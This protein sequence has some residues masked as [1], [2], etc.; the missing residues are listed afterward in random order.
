M[1]RHAHARRRRHRRQHRRLYVGGGAVALVLAGI[2]LSGGLPFRSGSRADGSPGPAA[3]C[4]LPAIELRVI[5]S[6]EKVA[7][8]GAI[9]EAY[10][11]TEPAVDGRCLKIHIGHASSA[12]ATGLSGVATGVPG[13]PD[14]WTPESTLWVKALAT[15]S[16]PMQVVAALDHPSIAMSPTVL[17]MPRPM[18]EALGWP[19]QTL[20][21]AKLRELAAA[22]N[23]WASLGHPEWGAFRLDHIDPRLSTAKAQTTLALAYNVTGTV[24][25]LAADIA[26]EKVVRAL[27]KLDRA[28]GPSH[29]DT[30]VFLA[31]LRDADDAG[32][33]LRHISVAALDEMSVLAYN[34]GNSLG[35]PM[36]EDRSDW[37]KIPLAAFYP[38]EGTFVSDHPYV[39]LT[40]AP[41]RRRAA[42]TFLEHLRTPAAQAT[43][44]RYGFRDRRGVSAAEVTADQGVLARQPVKILPQPDPDVASALLQDVGKLRTRSNVLTVLDVSGSMA[45]RVSGQLTR[46]DLAKQAAI[47]SLALYDAHDDGGLWSFTTRHRQLVSLGPLNDEVDGGATRRDLIRAQIAKL[48]PGNDTALYNTAWAAHQRVVANYQRDTRNSVILLTDGRNDI[49]GGLNLNALLARLSKSDRFRPVRI[50]LIAYGDNVDLPALRKIAAAT[51][52]QVFEA[53]NPA[54]IDRVF[55]LAIASS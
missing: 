6:A 5:S 25:P 34:H 21:L 12:L 50:N 53:P 42:T 3:R 43:L 54:N 39:I 16:T 24:R 9:A 2:V 35:V 8:L 14:V 17:A 1:A 47:N 51:G 11:K 10:Q 40:D 30:T 28:P 41:D 46:M 38:P 19:D 22:K 18:A 23:G 45:V 36:N 15:S 20:G 4:A 32:K 31:G 29:A 55:A 49:V 27:L 26:S 33:A 48:T 7:A 13:R 37:P 52:G 44:Q